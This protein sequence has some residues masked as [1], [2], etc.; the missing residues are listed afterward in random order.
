MNYQKEKWR[1]HDIYNV[2]FKNKM[3]RNTF[4]EVKNLYYKK[5]M[6]RTEDDQINWK[7]FCIRGLEEW[8][9][10]KCDIKPKATYRFNVLPIKIPVAFFTEINNPR[11]CVELQKTPSSKR[12]FEKGQKS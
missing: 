5:L 1:K 3:S 12:N 2:I 6:K 8:I 10:L 7:T 11:L 4:N 9:S